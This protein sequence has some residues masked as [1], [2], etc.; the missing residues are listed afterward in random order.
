MQSISKFE[1]WEH[2]RIQQSG[3]GI[4]QERKEYKSRLECNRKTYCKRFYWYVKRKCCQ[5]QWKSLSDRVKSLLENQKV[6]EKINIYFVTIFTEDRENNNELKGPQWIKFKEINLN[7][8]FCFVLMELKDSK[9]PGPDK[10]HPRA[11]GKIAT[12]ME[13]DNWYSH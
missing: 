10:L 8:F 2:L 7:L 13:D 4:D 11:L 9:F 5:R 1:D 12:E 6:E 3:Q